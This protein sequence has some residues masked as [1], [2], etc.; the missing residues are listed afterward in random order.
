MVDREEILKTPDRELISMIFVWDTS[1]YLARPIAIV[2]TWRLPTATRVK[3]GRTSFVRCCDCTVHG[4][5]PTVTMKFVAKKMGTKVWRV[6][7]FE[8]FLEESHVFWVVFIFTPIWGR[9]PF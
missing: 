9:F 5:S 2:A 3:D 1:S 7:D 6:D 8:A 4:P